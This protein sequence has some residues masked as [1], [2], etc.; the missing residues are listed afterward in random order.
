MKK[1]IFVLT[2]VMIGCTLLCAAVGCDRPTTSV[3]PRTQTQTR[4]QDSDDDPALPALPEED[5]E[6]NGTRPERP[7]RPER[8]DGKCPDG[9]HGGRHKKRRAPR[10]GEKPAPEEP[11]PENGD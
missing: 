11:L 9:K 1:I 7:E 8:P 3:P 4:T 6:Q 5:G 2:T 10:K